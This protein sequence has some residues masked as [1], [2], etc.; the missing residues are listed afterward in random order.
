[1]AWINLY[2]AVRGLD[3]L[4]LQ[5]NMSDIY[6]ISGLNIQIQIY[7][8]L[9]AQI[10]RHTIQTHL[11]LRLAIQICLALTEIYR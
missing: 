1:M 3:C 10:Y 11:A 6:N 5:M 4:V 8:Y 7:T 9:W 2:A